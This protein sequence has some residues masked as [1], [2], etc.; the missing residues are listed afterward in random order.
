MATKYI[1][2]YFMLR[3]KFV[4][5]DSRFLVIW[6]IVFLLRVKV[7]APPTA[8]LTAPGSLGGKD[9]SVIFITVPDGQQQWG[10]RRIAAQKLFRM[11][12]RK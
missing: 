9:Y 6:F 2:D 1:K 7:V 10:N 5:F 3:C 11:Q 12:E 8:A 4:F